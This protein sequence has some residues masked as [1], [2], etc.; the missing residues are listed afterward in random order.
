MMI[1]NNTGR[2]T[3]QSKLYDHFTSQEYTRY[4]QRR[5]K[6][7]LCIDNL[8]RKQEEELRKIRKKRND[9][10]EEWYDLDNKNDE[11]YYGHYSR[12]Y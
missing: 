10:I 2:D 11:N 5:I 7:K 4:I 1:K 8:D 12:R 9:T 3:E 6:L